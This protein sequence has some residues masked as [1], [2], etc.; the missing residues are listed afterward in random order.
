MAN[1][2]LNV[3]QITNRALMIL[4][5]KLNF[6]GSINRNYDNNF[7]QEGAKIGSTLRIR[8]PN[9][10]TVR[11]GAA[12]SLQ[13]VAE[14]NTTLA[15]T[16]QKGVDTTFSSAQLA[17][18]IFDFSQQVLEP[19]MA[20][21]AANIEAD[22]FAMARDVYNTVNGSGS[23]Q[24][25]RNMLQARKVLKDNLAPNAT[26]MAR[27]DTQSNV[28][29]VDSLKGLFQ[30]SNKIKKQYEDGVIGETGGFEFAENTLLPS[31]TFGAR[32]NAYLTN[33]AVAQTGSS[34]IVDTGA[35]AAAAGD[36]FTIGGVF[37]VHP[38]TKAST[39]ILQQ[40]VVTA[41][42]AGGAGTI[43]IAPAIVASGAY[44]NVS[45][46]AADNQA[47]TFVGTASATTQ[48]SLCY[49][50]DA[51]TF[52]TADLILPDGVHFAA[53][54]VQDGIS[55]RVVRQY[56]I[57]NDLMPCRLDVLYGFKAIRPQ[58]ACRVLAN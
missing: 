41:A 42:Y 46:G 26:Y 1:T 32:N 5:Q 9:Q 43:S 2:L 31:F 3:D 38:E 56:D 10:Y 50:P 57:N 20:V 12:L 22:A 54:K 13:D 44:Q 24:T 7:A 47:I 17:L 25:L 19:A 29:L 36:V 51:F 45:N 8:L 33:S 53:R 15:V 21:L 4:H 27:I 58:L 35:N 39:G 40:F 18:S 23:S 34:L 11:S 48:Q 55:M 28:D 49:H 16:N 14:T 52:A 6:I 37:R 30:S